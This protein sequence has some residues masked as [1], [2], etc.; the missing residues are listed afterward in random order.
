M[1][2][3]IKL[4]FTSIKR[5][6]MSRLEFKNDTLIAMLAF[7]IENICSILSIYFVVSAIPALNIAG[8]GVW[9]IWQIGFLYGFVML[10]KGVDHLFTDELWLVCYRRV[11]D[12]SL[13]KHFLKPAP[14]LF[15]VISET[16]QPEG[17]GEIFLGIAMLIICGLNPSV[18]L[19]W[20]TGNVVLLLVAIIFGALIISAFKIMF[21]GLAFI[22]KR[23]G[24]MFQIIYNSLTYVKYPKGIFPAF[25]RVILT[26]IIPFMLVTTI[27]AE[28]F[29]GFEVFNPWLL[30]LIIIGAAIVLLTIAILIWNVCASKYEST[31]N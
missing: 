25:I 8:Q 28:I 6:I 9:N 19:M 7:T 17:F 31:G 23:T 24:P 10:P 12:G 13:D 11:T 20:S 4:Y 21:A 29:L 30:S 18:T 5:S 16:F 14:V 1:R 22:L 26:G 3:Y 2:H 15:M 27:P